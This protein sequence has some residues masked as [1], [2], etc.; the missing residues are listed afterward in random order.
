MG[1]EPVLL[2]RT[3]VDALYTILEAIA[4]ALDELNVPWILTGGSLLGS[5]RQHSILF[6]DDD[7]DLALLLINNDDANRDD[8]DEMSAKLQSKLGPDFC[9]ASK[10]WEGG[11]RLRW[12][13]ASNVFVDIFRIREYRNEGELRN[14][15]GT[16]ANGQPQPKEYVDRILES[17]EKAAFSHG[18]T[19]PLYPCWQF[20]SRKAIELWPKEVYRT[21]ELFPIQ[22]D[23]RMGPI[24]NLP[25]PKTPVLLL[26]RAF[27]HDCFE[28]Y[29][30]SQSHQTTMSQSGLLESNASLSEHSAGQSLPPH[31]KPGGLWEHA[32]KTKLL[33]EH[34]IPIQPVVKSRRRPTSHNQATLQDYLES[35][36]AKESRWIEE[37]EVLQNQQQQQQR[38]TVYMDGV[39]DLFHI[40]H[41]RA[42]EQCAALG[43]RVILG[44]TGDRDASSYKR[45]PIV[46]QENRVAVLEGLSAV[47][48]V[49][50]PCPLV[51]SESFMA[52]HGIDLVVHGFADEAD[53][54]RQFE[55]FEVPIRMGKFQRI[56][57][58]RGLSTSDIINKIQGQSDEMPSPVTLKK[59]GSIIRS[60]S[61]ACPVLDVENIRGSIERHIAKSRQQRDRLLILVEEKN[62]CSR[63][64]LNDLLRPS[65]LEA[66]FGYDTQKHPLRESFLK[67]THF[68]YGMDLSQLHRYNGAKNRMF[69]ALTKNFSEFQQ[70]FCAFVLDVCTQHFPNTAD[71]Y[72]QSFP[73]IRIIQPGDFSIGPHCDLVYGHHPASVNFYVPLTPIYGTSSLYLESS[74]GKEDWHPIIGNYGAIK[75]FPGAT[76]LHWT[77][78]NTTEAT[79]VSLDVRLIDGNLFRS[80]QFPGSASLRDGYYARCCKS[81]TTGKW[82]LEGELPTPSSRM[83]FPWTVNEWALLL[84]GEA[85]V[86]DKGEHI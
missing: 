45:A 10:V 16:K 5:V 46:N 13:K 55:F 44:V 41:L 51:V 81:E 15:I 63:D 58:Y 27:G 71:V 24:L 47:D 3:Q 22:K 57:Y 32:P 68:S 35:Q 12:K 69:H 25:G 75:K 33:P 59:F 78:E 74:I 83:G 48:K 62:N 40:G 23:Y 72:F 67:A 64:E 18:E 19:Q 11:D 17:I 77:P 65:S 21:H 7:V 80:L 42:I 49:I 8:V 28:V 9:Y 26:Q 54:E 82:V 36:R 29:F 61:K 38:Y 85:T 43:D 4:K 84:D 79:R 76:C 86:R 31:V 52:E 56:N 70:V 50:C 2:S 73:C 60:I 6:T 30:Q 34:Y 20:S 66:D 1:P 37:H 53:A 14:V 39:F